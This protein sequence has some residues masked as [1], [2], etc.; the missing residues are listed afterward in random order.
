VLVERFD[1]SDFDFR[2]LV[3]HYLSNVIASNLIKAI[4]VDQ[5]LVVVSTK[6]R[7]WVNYS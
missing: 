5:L 6:A 3:L 4:L 7:F 1:L 2:L